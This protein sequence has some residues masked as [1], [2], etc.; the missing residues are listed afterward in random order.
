ME[1]SQKIKG[2]SFGELLA[3]KVSDGTKT[4]TRRLAKDGENAPWQVG[5]LLYVR[6]PWRTGDGL[7]AIRPSAL[8][9]HCHIE[10]IGSGKEILHGRYRQARFMP[11]KFATTFIRV[12]EVRK[13]RLQDIS[14]DD[15]IAEGIDCLDVRTPGGD[16]YADYYRDYS[17]P[18]EEIGG[19]PWI[20][21]YP[22]KSFASLW[23]YVNHE[24]GKP[25]WA[26]NSWVWVIKFERVNMPNPWNIYTPF[27][28]QW[29]R[30]ELG[31][32]I[33]QSRGDAL[34]TGKPLQHYR[35][36]VIKNERGG[37][38]TG[39]VGKNEVYSSWSLLNCQ[40]GTVLAFR[41]DYLIKA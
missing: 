13:E 3:G 12:L 24:K 35:L 20:E 19:W 18:Y 16:D 41:K 10:F 33:W 36:Q 22:I 6:R 8:A 27:E 26:D 28:V 37:D 9:D 34:Q 14:E 40:Q 1:K 7:D 32:E 39:F 11:K 23:D 5:Q 2:I 4:Q 30:D 31:R 25:K 15:A 29:D 21:G 38:Y 17:Q